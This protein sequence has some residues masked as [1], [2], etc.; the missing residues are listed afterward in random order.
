M[1]GVDKRG[2]QTPNEAHSQLTMDAFCTFLASS[3]KAVLDQLSSAVVASQ[4]SFPAFMSQSVGVCLMP[5]LHLWIKKRKQTGIVSS[6]AL[7]IKP[8]T[9]YL[10]YAIAIVK[11]T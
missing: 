6:F 11:L 2:L 4:R 9:I 3:S 1:W 10:C 7:Q 5:A 8:P